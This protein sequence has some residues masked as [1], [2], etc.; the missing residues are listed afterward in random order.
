MSRDDIRNMLEG[1]ALVAARPS[2]NHARNIITAD[3]IAELKAKP[4]AVC[5][6]PRGRADSAFCQPCADFYGLEARIG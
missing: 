3:T 5:S 4:C 2:S 1:A 6:K